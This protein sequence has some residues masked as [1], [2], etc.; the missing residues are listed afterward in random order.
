MDC[1]KVIKL[2][3]LVLKELLSDENADSRQ[4]IKDFF[5]V[6]FEKVT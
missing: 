6:N 4:H 5:T 2:Y 1:I 3:S